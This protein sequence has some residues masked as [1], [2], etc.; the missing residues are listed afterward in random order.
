MNKQSVIKLLSDFVGIESVAADRARFKEVLRA[1][2]FLKKTLEEMNFEVKIINQDKASPLVVAQKIVSKNAE[3]I[4]IYGHYDVQPEDPITEWQTKPFELTLENGKFYGR[5]VADNKGHIIQNIVSINQ[6]TDTKH[7]K[8]NI[9]FVF[10]G[11]EETGS[12]HFE[13]LCQEAKKIL[14]QANVFYMTDMGLHRKN[15]PQIFYA[16]RGNNYYELTVTIG[17]RDLHSGVYGNRVYNP[18]NVLA[19]LIAKIKDVHTNKI[20]IP[21]FY[22]QVRLPDK[23]EMNLLKK[24]VRKQAEELSSAQVFQLVPSKIPSSLISKIYPSF[25]VHGIIGG[26]ISEGGKTVIPKTAMVKFS[27]RLVENQ[28]AEIIDQ[29]VKKFVSDNLPEGVKFELKTLSKG[30]P[31]YTDFNNTYIEKTSHLLSK[32]FGHETIMNRSGGSVHAAGVLQ[33]LFKKPVILI[34]FTLPDDRIHAPNENFD[35]EMFWKGIKA[36]KKIYSA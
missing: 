34:G 36:L 28:K 16:L 30:E 6:L 20:L 9:I 10:E 25:D 7:L 35:E 19:D 12:S 14:S 4:G 1:V 13:E 17:K 2:D 11:E 24:V 29:L 22:D 23:K 21:H 3:T 33:K 31:F 15:E 27:F 18:I 26:Y 32:V 8:N 5:G